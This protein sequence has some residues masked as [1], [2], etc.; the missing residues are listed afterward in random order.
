MGDISFDNEDFQRLN[1]AQQQEFTYP[2]VPTQ[3]SLP[4]QVLAK[5]HGLATM[6]NASSAKVIE[7]L[8][9]HS[10]VGNSLV[11][12]NRDSAHNITEA[13]NIGAKFPGVKQAGPG[14]GTGPEQPAVS[15]Q[16]LRMCAEAKQ[17][18][19]IL[20]VIDFDATY[21][22]SD[23]P[24]LG[25]LCRC[26]QIGFER[27]YDELAKRCQEDQ[28]KRQYNTEHNLKP[29]DP[30]YQ[31]GNDQYN[32]EHNLKP[33]DEGYQEV[34]YGKPVN[35]LYYNNLKD[36]LKEQGRR[37]INSQYAEHDMPW[38]D[39]PKKPDEKPLQE[40]L[41]EL[42]FDPKPIHFNSHGFPNF[43][44]Y[45]KETVFLEDFNN[46]TADQKKAWDI[47]FAQYPEGTVKG[48]YY[49]ELEAE[50]PRQWTWHHVEDCHT[51]QL[52]PS[53]LNRR[54]KHT[55]GTALTQAG[56]GAPYSIDD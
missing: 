19:V 25:H 15:Q 8:G 33:G 36:K 17:V 56:L 9:Q 27:L 3:F 28:K 38:E 53:Q 22:I 47:L 49:R 2:A 16:Q 51:M 30:G 4:A 55:G 46:N 43:G 31:P 6:Q 11:H 10:A 52:V 40:V 44:P 29:G 26:D 42:G 1:A 24:V 5:L 32:T 34:S 21:H 20:G 7:H 37:I 50:E 45:T 13:F 35:Y 48:D 54:V 14:G 23:D 41:K 18:A 12:K 39:V